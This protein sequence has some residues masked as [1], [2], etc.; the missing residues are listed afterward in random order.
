MH[1]QLFPSPLIFILIIFF[2]FLHVPISLC[3]DD[4][5]R[6]LNCSRPFECG[7]IRNIYPFWG[8][9]RPDYCGHPGFELECHDDITEIQIMTERYRVLGITPDSQTLKVARDDFWNNTCPS[10]F[11]NTTLNL[12]IFNYAST[13][14]SLTLRYNCTINNIPVIP[15]LG[16]SSQFNCSINQTTLNAFF[17]T[18][19]ISS[20]EANLWKCNN[21]VIVP[22]HLTAASALERNA[23]TLVDAL[24]G[25]FE[26]QWS[27]V[28][29]ATCN[30]CLGS[31]GQCGYNSTSGQLICFCRDQPYNTTCL[32]P[33]TSSASSL[34][35][36]TLHLAI[37]SVAVAAS[38]AS[39]PSPTTALMSTTTGGTTLYSYQSISNGAYLWLRWLHHLT[40]APNQGDLDLRSS[41]PANSV[42]SS[43]HQLHFSSQFS[44]I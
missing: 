5:E 3:N 8:R 2:V 21:N 20:T 30:Q 14:R 15:T 41:S 40:P 1:P 12:T 25:G 24:D 4:D 27:T 16:P 17:T 36:T 22:V 18:R 42:A 44:L 19:P 13:A 38:P 35:V 39:F 33:G 6:Y 34:P 26:L 32:T 7:S 9:D 10:R 37:A 23:T 29:S 28:G 43:R 31:G 11:A